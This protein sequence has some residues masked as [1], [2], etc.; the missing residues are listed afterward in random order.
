MKTKTV[1]YADLLKLTRDELLKQ[2]ITPF[3]KDDASIAQKQERQRSKTPLLGKAMA[4]LQIKFAEAQDK[5][6]LPKGLSFKEWHKQ[7]TG[8]IPNN[9]VEQCAGAYRFFVG[10]KLMTEEDYDLS[11]ADWLTTAYTI[12]KE[13]KFDKDST[14]VKETTALL[15]RPTGD[16]AKQLRELKRD[17]KGQVADRDENG[18]ETTKELTAQMLV[19]TL[20]VALANKMRSLIFAELTALV[21]N[22]HS[23][24]ADDAE[25]LYNQTRDLQDA[26]E[27]SEVTPVMQA[28]W[29]DNRQ[30]SEAKLKQFKAP[31]K[32]TA[33]GKELV[34]A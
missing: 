25:S 22:A 11:G 13:T 28:K 19:A 5:D 32:V 16:T 17:V 9:H 15:K 27:R 7:Q 2:Y 4:A 18:K 33:A 26:W 14:A 10:T 24:K 6:E 3:V 30:S 23:M 1:P 29:E 8:E 21:L 34:P 20:R 31:M 12:A